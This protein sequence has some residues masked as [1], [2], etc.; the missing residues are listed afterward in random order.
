MQLCKI[1]SFQFLASVR[2]MREHSNTNLIQT[3]SFVSIPINLS[4]GLHFEIYYLKG[5]LFHSEVVFTLFFLI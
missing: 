2:I 3:L 1:Y 5:L 4:S